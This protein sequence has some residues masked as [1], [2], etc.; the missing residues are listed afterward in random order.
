MSMILRV[1]RKVTYDYVFENGV[2]LNDLLFINDLK[3]YAKSE[4]GSEFRGGSRLKLKG[5]NL[6]WGHQKYNRK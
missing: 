6:E 3:L 2:K 4:K 5:G 1:L